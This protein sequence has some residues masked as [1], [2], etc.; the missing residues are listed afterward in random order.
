[1]F[2]VRAISPAVAI[3]N[4]ELLPVIATPPAV[5]V[6]SIDELSVPFVFTIRISS[7][8]AVAEAA[9]L[10]YASRA[11]FPSVKSFSS[12]IFIVIPPALDV[13]AIASLPVAV[14]SIAIPPDPA[15]ISNAVAA[16]ELPIEIILSAAP[17][18]IFIF[19]A[20]SSLPIPIVPPLELI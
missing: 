4:V 7:L 14:V 5:D 19:C 13:N 16:V 17:V 2:A 11:A 8:P 18:P 6:N 20:T 1:M 9:T 12:A 10:I 15:S 3:V